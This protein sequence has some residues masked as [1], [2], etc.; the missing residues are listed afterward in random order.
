[1]QELAGLFLSDHD[2]LLKPDCFMDTIDFCDI[3]DGKSKLTLYP[4]ND[5]NSVLQS[6][7]KWFFFF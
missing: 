2:I 1:M 6:Q 4:P 3:F 5:C 7:L